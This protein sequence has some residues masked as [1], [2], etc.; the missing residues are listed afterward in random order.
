VFTTSTF[1]FALMLAIG[2]A[3]LAMAV[4]EDTLGTP[5]DAPEEEKARRAELW[6]RAQFDRR[7][8]RDLHKRLKADMAQQR[9]VRRDFQRKRGRR[10][11]QEAALDQDLQRA[12][13]TTRDEIA[14]VEM[15]LRRHQ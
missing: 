11:G 5:R 15:W 2:V 3:G 14:K 9:A 10:G 4:G 6:T 7:A 12:E 1:F 13:R 8:A